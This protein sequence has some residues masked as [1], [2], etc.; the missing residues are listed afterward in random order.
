M[1]LDALDS[2]WLAPLGPDVDA[3]EREIAEAT[4]SA[5]AVA[6]S[7]GTAALHLAMRLLSIGPGD[8]VLAPTLTFIA[9]VAAVT[10][11]GAEPL[12]IDADPTTWNI[13]PELLEAEL[14]ERARMG[15]LP[16][17]VVVVDLYGRCADYDRIIPLCE[18]YGV[19]IV[20]DA[21]EALGAS[22]QGRPAGSFGVIRALSFN[23]NKI[24]TT[25]GGGM[26]LTDDPAHAA[27]AQHLARQAQVP[28]PHYEHVEVGY[29]YRLSNLL[30]ALGRAQLR[31]LGDRVAAKQA[32]WSRYVD[33]LGEVA[34]L[35]FLPAEDRGSWNAWLSTVTIDPSVFAATPNDVRM[36]L[37]ALDIEARAAWKPMH[38]QPVYAGAASRLHGV[39]ERAFRHG[40]CLPSGAGLGEDGQTRVIAAVRGALGVGPVERR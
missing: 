13:D 30:A 23:G 3:F 8:V 20:E 6:V 16:K 37:E 4:G 32:V 27:R 35:S 22:W 11:V 34:G 9:S 5:C 26:L 12:F 31:T 15:T 38:L 7:S 33:E 29:N 10:Y 19:P 2:N 14:V 18:H 36:F 39:A 1:L 28:G 17:A 40:L 21:A 25:S 24:I